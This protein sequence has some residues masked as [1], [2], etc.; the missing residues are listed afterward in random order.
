MP[1]VDGSSLGA[2]R[3]VDRSRSGVLVSWPDGD[4][5]LWV[6]R[7]EGDGGDLVKKVAA[8]ENVVSELPTLG[9][10]GIAV[11][12]DHVLQT[13]HRRVRATSVVVWTDGD[14][15]L[16][17]DGTPDRTARRHRPQLAG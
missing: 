17:L 3:L 13:P 11:S 15:M 1:P 12:G 8:G 6:V 10:G 9:D 16:Q 5:S 14:L 4:T 2:E 7:V